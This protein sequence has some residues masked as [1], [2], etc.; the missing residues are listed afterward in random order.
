MVTPEMTLPNLVK[1]E[2]HDGTFLRQM[3]MLKLLL[4]E[5]NINFASIASASILEKEVSI[6]ALT[7]LKI[8]TFPLVL[9]M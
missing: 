7:L 6:T 8:I 4:V 2:L 3:I 1:V 9:K 5:R